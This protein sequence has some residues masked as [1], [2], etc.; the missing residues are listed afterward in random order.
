LPRVPGI[1]GIMRN[2][3]IKKFPI[4]SMISIYLLRKEVYR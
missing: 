2:M 3:K 1:S 4:L